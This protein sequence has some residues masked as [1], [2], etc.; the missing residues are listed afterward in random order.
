MS[1]ELIAIIIVGLSNAA[2]LA[3]LWALH[4]EVAGLRERLARVEER[5]VRLE[6]RMM[7]VEERLAR[8]EECM[9]RFGE[10][11]SRLEKLFDRFSSRVRE[12]SDSETGT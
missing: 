10:R 9:A 5:F 2:S 11:L 12:A 7:R 6:E 3:F 4:H 1:P 8:L